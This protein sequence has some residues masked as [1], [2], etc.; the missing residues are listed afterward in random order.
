MGAV[1][2]KIIPPHNALVEARGYSQC[3]SGHLFYTVQFDK[4]GDLVKFESKEFFNL[5]TEE[6]TQ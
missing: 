1:S 2:I 3:I 4:L 6:G 5:M